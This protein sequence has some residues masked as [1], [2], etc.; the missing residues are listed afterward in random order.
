M[1]QLFAGATLRAMQ[2]KT[3]GNY[4]YIYLLE[5]LNFFLKKAIMANTSKNPE[6]LDL[7]YIV[8]L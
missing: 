3:M 2:I 6:N 5:E 7:S 4:H 8:K 1:S